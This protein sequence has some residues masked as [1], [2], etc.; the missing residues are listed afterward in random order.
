MIDSIYNGFFYFQDT[1]MYHRKF[2]G[3]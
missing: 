1:K 3:I 2:L